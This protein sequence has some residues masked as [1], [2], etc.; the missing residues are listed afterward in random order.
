M[1]R[2]LNDGTG[3]APK[4]RVYMNTDNLT[5][6]PG[7]SVWPDL[8]GREAVAQLEKN[9]F[10]G[11]QLGETEALTPEHTNGLPY[12]GLGRV[13]RPEEA[14]GLFARNRARGDSCI[15]LHV[16]WGMED[17]AEAHRLIEAILEASAHHDLPAF[18]ETHRATITQDM[19]R[20]VQWTKAFPEIRFNG[21]FSHFY[22]GQEMVY[23]D[24]EAK[25]DFMAPIFER[26]GFMHARIAAPGY[27]QAPIQTP[28]ARPQMAV[29]GARD[30]L[31]DFKEIWRR[32]MAGFKSNA[33]RGDVLIFTPELLCPDI[34]YARVFPDASGRLV[35]E[36]D[37]YAE[38][39]VYQK[40]ARR[41]FARA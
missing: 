13:N 11:L 16:G 14:D 41:I 40:I 12:C 6:L 9:G 27:M 26:V 21:D 36:S 4:L 34:Y 30:Y 20:T 33:A 38:A 8:A 28:D 15:T 29:E 31:S 25:L 37:R 32:A 19:W 10:E 7:H 3:D 2:Y 23:G 22:C 17:D 24:F 35:E 39:L 18:I 5:S 1:P